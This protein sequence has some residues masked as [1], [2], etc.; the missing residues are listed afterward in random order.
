[1]RGAWLVLFADHRVQV[2]G[3]A[4][5]DAAARALRRSRSGEVV[6]HVVAVACILDDE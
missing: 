3:R 4:E 6:T 5:A 1:V 2:V